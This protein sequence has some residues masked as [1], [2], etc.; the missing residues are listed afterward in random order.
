MVPPYRFC[1]VD[2]R[3]APRKEW[4]FLKSNGLCGWHEEYITRTKDGKLAK[5]LSPV[6]KLAARSGAKSD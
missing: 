1:E 6:F 5:R 3:I 4:L 2:G